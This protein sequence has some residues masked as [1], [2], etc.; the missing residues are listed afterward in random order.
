MRRS[1]TARGDGRTV[2]SPDGALILVVGDDCHLCD[3]GRDVLSALG[4]RAR[5]VPVG[6]DEG[7]LLAERGI[8]LA[9]L[10]VLTDGVRVIAYGRL[11]ERRLRR[12][13]AS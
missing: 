12:D 13:L 8:P 6:S 11:S 5:E 9:F 3:H 4:L 2:A 1:A 10:P 7:R